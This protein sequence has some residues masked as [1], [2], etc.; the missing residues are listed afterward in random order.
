M[1]KRLEDVRQS[2]LICDHRMKTTGRLF[3]ERETQDA[4]LAKQRAIPEAT[5]V[6]SK[7]GMVSRVGI[8]QKG[9]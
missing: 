4:I 2:P 3:R 1:F 9:N 8:A 7:R 5:E 6:K